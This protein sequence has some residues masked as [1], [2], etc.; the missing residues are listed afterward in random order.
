MEHLDISPYALPSNKDQNTNEYLFEDPRDIYSIE[1]EFKDKA[2]CIPDIFYMQ[3]T[4]PQHRVEMADPLGNPFPF[5]W[6]PIDDHYN[7]KWQKASIISKKIGAKSINATFAGL[8]QEIPNNDDYNV[9]FRRTMG[10]RIVSDCEITNVKIFTASKS[11]TSRIKVYPNKRKNLIKQISIDTFNAEI[12]SISSENGAEINK[13]TVSISSDESCFEINVRHMTPAHSLCNDEGLITFHTDSTDFTISI[14]S[15]IENG[16]IWYEDAGIYITLSDNDI[17]FDDYTASIE[18]S[19]SISQILLSEQEQS[20]GGALGGQPRPHEVPFSIGCK[21]SKHRFWID[22]NGDITL[23][24][25]NVNW[26]ASSVKSRFMNDREGRFFFGF[27]KWL[28]AS[29]YTAQ[30]PT[31]AYNIEMTNDG[32]LMKQKCFAIPLSKSIFDEA[33]ADDITIAMVRFRFTNESLEN[34]TARLPLSYSSDAFRVPNRV[35]SKGSG[36]RPANI[37]DNNLPICSR[38]ELLLEYSNNNGLKTVYG[39]WHDKKPLRCIMETT[40]DVSQ[41]NNKILIEKE[42][43]PNESCELLVKIPFV[44]IESDQEIAALKQLDFDTCYS[45]LVKFWY[46]ENIKGA[47]IKTP[48]P[49]LNSLYASHL[50]YVHITDHV[51]QDDHYLINTSVGTSTYPNFSNESCMIIQELDQ[52]GLHDEARRR[53][54]VWLKY[55]GTV[56]LVGNFTDH[57]GVFYGAGGFECGET[58]NQHHGWIMWCLCEHYFMTNDSAWM[59][60]IADSIIKGAEWVFRQRRN[61]LGQLPNSYGIE[62]GFIP[63]GSLEDVA[64]FYYWQS[65][66]TMTWRG[67]DNAARALESIGHPA[68]PEIRK[69]SDEYKQ[70]LIEGF[71]KARSLN[72]LVKLK[73]GRWIPHFPSR[74]YRRGRDIGWIREVLEGA[75]YL[76]ISGLYDASSKEADWIL[77]DYLDN[78]YMDSPNTYV[79]WNKKSNWFDCSG[80]SPQPNLLAGLIPHLDRDEPEIYIWMFFNAWA[81][82]YREE[83]N[84]MIEHPSPILGFSNAAHPKTSDESNA[85][86]WLRYMFVYGNNNGLYIGRA[87]P[88]E[89][90][91][92]GENIYAKGVCTK[93]GKVSV[94]YQSFI[95]Q[96]FAAASVELNVTNQPK[97]VLVRFRHPHK[98]SLKSV[99]INGMKTTKFD[100]AKGD[101][102]ITGL[103]GNLDIKVEYNN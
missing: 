32:I 78:R 45:D 3:K 8:S 63:A 47:Q 51:M 90:F 59:N 43:C 88:R 98:K 69:Q 35:D 65:T 93:H 20:L 40:M 97:E 91:N 28:T 48:E 75:V 14:Q 60:E 1:I 54:S 9:T 24:S 57:D 62:K 23:P 70:S 58:Y 41:S 82:C 17:S 87:L 80:F 100:A 56:G 68:A 42:L 31:P 89:W 6:F 84:A 11:T 4:W 50:S 76:L 86:M 55:Q 49:K 71:N 77:D 21:G 44:N 12:I 64:D 38:E 16:P 39:S 13:N 103:N 99:I 83:I 30:A 29:R 10:I 27:E 19:K 94:N 34:K 5:G 79:I 46:K 61:T 52:R 67:V 25:F 22:P 73:D 7:T 37:D 96:N 26:P 36:M 53:L 72:P 92:D 74:L 102:D 66:N 101:I 2:A 81:A 15:L 85:I 33:F 95:K 18:G